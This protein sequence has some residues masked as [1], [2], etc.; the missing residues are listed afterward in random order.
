MIMQEKI[1]I[2]ID[3]ELLNKVDSLIG[4]GM[5]KKRSQSIEYILKKY[6]EKDFISKLVV[7][8]GGAANTK[9]LQLIKNIK[10]LKDYGINE[11]F[12]I[13]DK[14]LDELKEK[15]E[16]LQLKVTLIKETEPL[17]TAGALR[18]CKN[19]LNKEF[20]LIFA[21]IEFEFDFLELINLH[22]IKKAVATIGVTTIREGVVADNIILEGNQIKFYGQGGGQLTNTGTYIFSPSI[23]EYLPEKGTFDKD[24]FP[25]LAKEGKLYAYLFTDIWK[26]YTE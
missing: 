24:V 15:I 17:G 2:S 13:S 3:E 11:V 18:L 23:F 10:F 6:F 4:N 19:Y 20:A 21:N 16:D 25:V 1:S 22:K 7:L 8:V 14:D 12:L 26:R 5:I 9:T